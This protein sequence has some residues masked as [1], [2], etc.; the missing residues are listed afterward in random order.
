[1]LGREL[2]LPC[3]GPATNPLGN[4]AQG[5]AGSG[6]WPPVHRAGPELSGN[7]CHKSQHLLSSHKEPG[8][9]LSTL[10]VS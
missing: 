9:I 6:P 10:Q 7:N 8:A 2:T 5:S 1:M 4:P 3:P